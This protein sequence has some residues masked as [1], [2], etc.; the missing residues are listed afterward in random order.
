MF[1]DFPPSQTQ[2]VSHFPLKPEESGSPHPALASG[3]LSDSHRNS[4]STEAGVS[5][6][7][8][9]AMAHPSRKRCILSLVEALLLYPQGKRIPA[10]LSC[11]NS[12]SCSRDALLRG[13]VSTED[14]LPGL[15]PE[16]TPGR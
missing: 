2:N 11:C 12:Y 8:H 15:S 9:L 14:C 7:N 6:A 10:Y 5:A 1:P 3:F 13:P 4:S 16:S